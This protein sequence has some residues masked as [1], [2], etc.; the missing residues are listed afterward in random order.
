MKILLK[1]GIFRLKTI[2]CTR[3]ET[4]KKSMRKEK[5]GFFKGPSRLFI[6][7][8]IWF[9]IYVIA[10]F[11][12]GIWLAASLNNSTKAKIWESVM[13]E[14]MILYAEI[15]VDKLENK[16]K[17]EAD[18][19][20]KRIENTGQLNISLYDQAGRRLIGHTTF[21]NSRDIIQEISADNDSFLGQSPGFLHWKPILARQVLG[22]SGEK[23]II[24]GEPAGGFLHDIFYSLT[25]LR[26][27]NLFV[28]A[29]IFSYFL[30]QYLTAPIR[31]LQSATLRLARGEL[32]ARVDL[33]VGKRRDELGYLARDFNLMA[34]KIE[35]LEDLRRQLLSDVSHELRSPLTRLKVALDLHR[36]K[37][38]SETD[39][40]LNRIELESDRLNE[41]IEKLLATARRNG[42]EKTPGFFPLNLNDLLLE[43]VH[44]ANFEIQPDQAVV[45]IVESQDIRISGIKDLLKSAIENIIQNAVH[46]TSEGSAVHVSL[47]KNTERENPEVILRV[48]DHGKGVP[49]EMLEKIFQPFYRV[50]ASRNRQQG[51]TGLGLAISERA[52]RFHQGTIKATNAPEGGLLVEVR[53]PIS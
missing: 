48:R 21:D 1:T 41:L 14:A 13:S 16:G 11:A 28:L 43:I 20:L 8:F 35:L 50:D 53:L 46:F 15:V 40:Y 7:I 49:K 27:L 5:T 2:F 25:I 32:S 18:A 52:V 9:C 47:T 34:E 51:G 38:N 3:P 19:Y 24:V 26:I 4:T 45:E 44:D 17:T 23:Y 12:L 31:K 30:A 39:E 6:K 37:N 42:T 33:P 22:G 29:L 10:V 36:K